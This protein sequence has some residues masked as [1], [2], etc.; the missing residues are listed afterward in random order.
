M[1][2]EVHNV[3]NKMFSC[4]SFWLRGMWPHLKNTT[5]SFDLS[6]RDY[7]KQDSA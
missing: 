6:S 5:I 3:K 4:S 2:D 7:A 1:H